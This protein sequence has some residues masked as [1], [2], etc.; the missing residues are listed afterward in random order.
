MKKVISVL[1][2]LV[3][4]AALAACGKKEEPAASG[5]SDVTQAVDNTKDGIRSGQ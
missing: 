4:I 1:M 2:I 3:M 5:N